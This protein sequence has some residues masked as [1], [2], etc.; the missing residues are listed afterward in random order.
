MGEKRAPDSVYSSGH[1]GPTTFY[2]HNNAA[3]FDE[4]RAPDGTEIYPGY[5]DD[6]MTMCEL[7]R[8]WF[9]QYRALVDIPTD[10]SAPD[11]AAE[12]AQLREIQE[13]DEATMTSLRARLQTVEQS[14]ASW[15]ASAEYWRSKAQAAQRELGVLSAAVRWALGEE[16]DFAERPRDDKGEFTKGPYWWRKELRERAGLSCCC[17]EGGPGSYEGPR[18]NCPAHGDRAAMSA[19][20]SPAAPVLTL[21]TQYCCPFHKAGGTIVRACGEDTPAAPPTPR[22]DTTKGPCACGAWHSAAPVQGEATCVDCEWCKGSGRILSKHCPACGGSGWFTVAVP[23]TP[24]TS[25]RGH[26]LNCE[27]LAGGDCNCNPHTGG[28]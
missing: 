23:P 21:A 15:K 27:S 3:G 28:R 25:A 10:A 12:N 7:L 17:A 22:C 19:P 20:A 4:L 13:H 16:G 1:P 8:Q 2:L 6:S 18:R 26:G 24:P 9:N 11:L 14:D 5:G